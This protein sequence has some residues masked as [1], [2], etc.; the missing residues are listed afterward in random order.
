MSKIAEQPQRRSVWFYGQMG[1]RD[2]DE[3]VE[4]AILYCKKTL[5]MDDAAASSPDVACSIGH[6]IKM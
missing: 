5:Q 3:K 2:H 6:T 4:A 1:R